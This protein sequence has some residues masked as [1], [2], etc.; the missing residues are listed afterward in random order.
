M[1]AYRSCCAC[2]AGSAAGMGRTGWRAAP[3]LEYGGSEPTMPDR[4]PS[5]PVCPRL[6]VLDMAGT[7]VEDGGQVPAAFSAALAHHGIAVTDEQIAAVRGSS[8]RE[9]IALVLADARDDGRRAALVFDTF[10]AC[11]AERYRH[12]GVRPVAGSRTCI[13]ILRARNIRVVLNTGFDRDTTTL[14][15]DALGWAD[16]VVDGLVC[17]DDVPRGRPAPYLIFAAM[18]RAGVDSV[19]EVANVGDTVLDLRAGH[20]AGVAWNVGVLS[21]AHDRDRLVREPHT[22]VLPSVADLAALWPPT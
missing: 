22:V 5:R 7:T 9:A 3:L 4:S 14:L 17:G 8:K 1:Y 15:V 13:D 21:G 10:R 6:V 20:H 18:A 19:H 12:N 16:G 2:V 11:L